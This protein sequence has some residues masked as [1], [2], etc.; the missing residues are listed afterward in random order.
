MVKVGIRALYR[1]NKWRTVREEQINASN[2]D[3]KKHKLYRYAVIKEALDFAAK[4][5][6]TFW[7]DAIDP[8]PIAKC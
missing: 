7:L 5:T 6:I 8:V 2:L 4:L 1:K 3:L